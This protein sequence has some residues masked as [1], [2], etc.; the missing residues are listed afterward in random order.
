M[1]IAPAASGDLDAIV[2]LLR[3]SG[4][5]TSDLTSRHLDGFLVA[6]ASGGVAPGGL[7]G[8]V[9]VEPYG[10]WG[11]LRSLVVAPEARGTGLGGALVDAAVARARAEGFVSLVLLTT[12][13][14]TF[15]RARGWA[16][17][18]REAVPL[19]VCRSSEFAG[20]CPAGAA[21]LVQALHQGIPDGP[22]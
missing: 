8:C 19:A 11:L 2:A 3:A 9:A 16:P 14:E 6:R 21:C 4:L 20:V 7:A 12:T 13:A 1:P 10:D 22:G 18:S 5:P 15:F 17:I